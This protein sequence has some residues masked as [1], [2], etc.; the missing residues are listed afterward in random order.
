MESQECEGIQGLRSGGIEDLRSGGTRGSQ[1]CGGTWGSQEYG[2]T[3]ISGVGVQRFS[4]LWVL[5]VSELSF[6]F[7]C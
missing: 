3:G 2:G 7:S 6:Q 4:E 1:E 5:R